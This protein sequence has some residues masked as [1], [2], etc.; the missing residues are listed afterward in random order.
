SD[1]VAPERPRKSVRRGRWR[2]LIWVLPAC[3]LLGAFAY[4]PL[5]QNL[6][7]SF[8]KWDIYSGRQTFV[9]ADNY[10]R[11]FHDPIFWKALVNNALYAVISIVFQVFGSLL[12][13]A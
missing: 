7:F 2:N 6:G 12:L 4:L 13:A 11:M 10:V 1:E 9:G 8:L 3:L 5:V